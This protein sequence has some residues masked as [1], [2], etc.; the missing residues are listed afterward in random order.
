MLE[1][2]AGIGTAGISLSLL[3]HKVVVS[4]REPALLQT[5]QDNIDLNGCQRVCKVLN[6]DWSRGVKSAQTRKLLA[7]QNFGCLIGAD[8]IYSP[9][10]SDLII[11]LLPVSCMMR[12]IRR[13]RRYTRRG[14]AKSRQTGSKNMKT[15]KYNTQRVTPAQEARARARARARAHTHTHT[16]TPG[17]SSSRWPRFV[18]ESHQTSAWG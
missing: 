5:M 10:M 18:R 3:G 15:Y 9:E 1:I 4:D 16:H 2:G 12:E 7:R 6:L 8:V 13:A 17:C 11:R 14:I